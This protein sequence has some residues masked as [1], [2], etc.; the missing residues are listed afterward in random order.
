[1]IA[2][3]VWFE[4][5][6]IKRNSYSLTYL[7]SATT[8]ADNAAL[9]AFA[10]RTPAVVQSLPAGRA[11]SS[12]PAAV[13]LQQLARARTDRQMDGHPTVTQTLRRVPCGLCQ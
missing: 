8:Y 10:C 11:H 2:V 12:K 7:C 9:P 4:Q 3:H 1:M 6:K 13:A 5:N